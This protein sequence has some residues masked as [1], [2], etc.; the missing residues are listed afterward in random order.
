[1][2]LEEITAARDKSEDSTPSLF[3]E[4]ARDLLPR[5][6]YGA[7]VILSHRNDVDGW[8]ALRAEMDVTPEE[9]QCEEGAIAYNGA[10]MAYYHMVARCTKHCE[11]TV[12][13]VIGIEQ[14]KFAL[15]EASESMSDAAAR[16]NVDVNTISKGAHKFIKGHK[17]PIPSCME[18]EESSK[19]HRAAR[20]KQLKD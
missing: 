16:L 15:G 9:Y 8:A 5:I 10:L 12:G 4:A 7:E 3:R 20:I 13:Q 18:D 11:D 1:M 17:L 19:A 2:I 14:L 6:I